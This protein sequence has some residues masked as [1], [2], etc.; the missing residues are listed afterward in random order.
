MP[1]T[2]KVIIKRLKKL[3]FEVIKGGKGSHTKMT[4]PGLLRPII[5]P[6]GELKKGTERSILKSA[7]LL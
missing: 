1:T 5:I 7:G 3:G 6:K 4:K 2:D